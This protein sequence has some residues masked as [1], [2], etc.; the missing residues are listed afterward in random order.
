MSAVWNRETG[1]PAMN[2]ARLSKHYDTLTPAERLTLVLAASGR[3]DEK[4]RDRLA[5]SAPRMGLQVPHHFGLF[6]AFYE[7]CQMH[8]LEMLNL[9][10]LYF[11]S[12][13]AADGGGAH[14][15][16]LLDSAKAF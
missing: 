1:R 15:A 16:R 4:E 8:R 3:G 14:G 13:G 2:T 11:R 5:A 6:M 9:A 12:H 10:A 7:L